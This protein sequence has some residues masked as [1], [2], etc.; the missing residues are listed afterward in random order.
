MIGIAHA[1]E[2]V[3]A[4]VSFGDDEIQSAVVTRGKPSAIVRR[5]RIRGRARAGLHASTSGNE[6]HSQDQL[7]FHHD[8]P[9]VGQSERDEEQ[10]VCRGRTTRKWRKLA[11]I[12]W[13]MGAL[14]PSSWGYLIVS[15]TD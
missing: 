14:A 4:Y 2:Q 9:C 13:L 8:T 5:H 12:A 6:Q 3:P 7:L 1:L 15:F 11:A 10:E